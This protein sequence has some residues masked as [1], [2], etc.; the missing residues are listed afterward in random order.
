MA[1]IQ[2]DGVHIEIRKIISYYCEE[3]NI[4]NEKDIG[5]YESFTITFEVNGERVFSSI[6]GTEFELCAGNILALIRM[7]EEVMEIGGF[8]EIEF[9]EPDF[10]FVLCHHKEEEEEDYLFQIW[11][12]SGVWE[13]IYSSTDMGFRFSLTREELQGFLDGLKKEW[14]QRQ[15]QRYT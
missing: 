5:T 10:S 1:F 13:K 14:E 9:L 6:I 2:K 11:V 8:Q 12:N 15:K 4:H 3:D 7:I